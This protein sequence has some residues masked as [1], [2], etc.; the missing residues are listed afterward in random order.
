MG[1]GPYWTWVPA[2]PVGAMLVAERVRGG[3]CGR[4]IHLSSSVY[5]FYTR[6]PHLEGIVSPHPSSKSP[7]CRSGEKRESEI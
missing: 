3:S 1:R 6:P 2:E 4:Y 7:N 5:S